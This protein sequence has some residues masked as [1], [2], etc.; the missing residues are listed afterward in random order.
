MV[1]TK[2]Y[3]RLREGQMSHFSVPELPFRT[4]AHCGQ[5]KPRSEFYKETRGKDGIRTCCKECFRAADTVRRASEP[6]KQREM[7]W[8]SQLK[9][10]YGIDADDYYQMMATQGGACAICGSEDGGG[11]NGVLQVDHDHNGGGVR[12]LLC[13]DCNNMLA[14]AHDDPKI[15]AAAAEYLRVHKNGD[16][17][18]RKEEV[19][20]EGVR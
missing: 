4:C 1:I 13:E 10:T 19:D 8:R 16:G 11:K 12:G 18:G 5:S 6:E 9:R 7:R 3:E 20:G 2:P 17:H 14:R 15:L